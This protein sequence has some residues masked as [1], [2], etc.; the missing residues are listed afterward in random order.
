MLWFYFTLSFPHTGIYCSTLPAPG[1]GTVTYNS[2]ADPM[3]NYLTE[4]TYSCEQG[5][6]LAEGSAVRVCGGNSST[7]WSGSASVCERE[8]DNNYYAVHAYFL[9]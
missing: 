6:G 4:A 1:N 7:E 5:L 9:Y 8:F 3:F 2:V